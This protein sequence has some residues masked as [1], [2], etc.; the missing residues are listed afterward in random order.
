M[1]L[2]KLFKKSMPILRLKMP[3]YHQCWA[4]CNNK[5]F[6]IPSIWMF[7]TKRPKIYW[8]PVLNSIKKIDLYYPSDL[9]P[10][11]MW[12]ETSSKNKKKNKLCGKI[13]SV[14]K[15]KIS[16]N[17]Q[18]LAYRA[19]WKNWTKRLIIRFK[20][21]NQ[22]WEIQLRNLSKSLLKLLK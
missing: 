2:T 12:A 6:N 16:P 8:I 3:K 11:D 22:L 13:L 4:S 1:I 17:L 14:L 15:A 5:I 10:V 20:F 9:K 19:L 7:W 21:K 18:I